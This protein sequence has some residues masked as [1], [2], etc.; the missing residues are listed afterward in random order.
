MSANP[1]FMQDIILPDNESASPIFDKYEVLPSPAIIDGAILSETEKRPNSG[2]I[3][4]ATPQ[5]SPGCYDISNTDVSE[6]SSLSASS[7]TKNPDAL[8]SSIDTSEQQYGMLD[9][10]F[11]LVMHIYN[12]LVKKSMLSTAQ[13]LLTESG[14]KHSEISVFGNAHDSFLKE[15]WDV[16][17]DVYLSKISTPSN[18]LSPRGFT[19]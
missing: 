18:P 4:P 12:Y 5:S 10:I 8:L 13:S 2:A 11:S 19:L 6:Y 15:W 1:T 3:N 7:S 14:L 17:W 16:F 9:L